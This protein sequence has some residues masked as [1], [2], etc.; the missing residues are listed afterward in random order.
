M[1]S[2][3]SSFSL[4][5]PCYNVGRVVLKTIDLAAD[6]LR[7]K[8][9][10]NFEIIAVD[11]GSSDH[12]LKYLR[13]AAIREPNLKV[14]AYEQNQGKG[15]A[16][17]TGFQKAS[18]DFI[19][20]IDADMDIPPQMLGRYI[21]MM[22]TGK[23]DCLAASK[24]HKNSVINRPFSR[25]CVSKISR[26]MIGLLFQLKGIDT[27][28]GLKV[29]RREVIQDIVQNMSETGFAFDIEMLV[30]IRKAGHSIDSAPV[31]IHQ[32]C[33]T[34]SVGAVSTVKTFLAVMKMHNRMHGYVKSHSWS[35][36]LA[37]AVLL[38]TF[39]RPLEL[40]LKASGKV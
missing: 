9:G 25:R 33:E 4:V 3:K 22:K 21:N 37:K 39:F 10:E 12:S 19:G 29:F 30:L 2:D 35:Y 5:L 27:Q 28:V 20:F 11:D 32:T 6:T 40:V 7:K 34:S 14:I 24:T 15:Y 38:I 16:I 18:G 36:A 1:N 26:E 13:L 31:Y 17:K 8:Y 23:Y